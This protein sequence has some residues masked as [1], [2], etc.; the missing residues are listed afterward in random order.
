MLGSLPAG[1]PSNR[2]TLARWLVEW[3]NPL[4]ARVAVNRLWEQYFG[5]GIVETSEDFGSRVTSQHP[6]LLD[7]LAVEFMEGGWR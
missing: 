5:R 3:S 1:E 2:L 4:T 6:E 7:W